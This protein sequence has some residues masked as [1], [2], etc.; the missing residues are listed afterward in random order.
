MQPD[1]ERAASEFRRMMGWIALAG[2]LMVIASLCYLSLYGPL[3]L[4]MVVAAIAGIFVSVLLGC[5]LFAA[6]FFSDKSG[7]DREVTDATRREPR[8]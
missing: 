4:H 7:H 5:G 8:D 2:A 3:R 6:A 1:R